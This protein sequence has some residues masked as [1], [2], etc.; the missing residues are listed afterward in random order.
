MLR[1]V[2]RW[3]LEGVKNFEIKKKKKKKIKKQ[4]TKQKKEIINFDKYARH[5][6]QTRLKKISRGE[7]FWVGI[8]PFFFSPNRGVINGV[9][10]TLPSLL[11]RF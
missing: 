6:V 11:K 5:S 3:G 9:R 8:A 4:K 7:V 10:L 1:E 2:T